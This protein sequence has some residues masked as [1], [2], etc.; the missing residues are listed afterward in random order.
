MNSSFTGGPALTNQGFDLLEKLLHMDPTQR[1]SAEDALKHDY[2][3]E[4]PLRKHE[5]MMPT[6][7]ATNAQSHDL[8]GGG[9]QQ[10]YLVLGNH[11]PPAS[12]D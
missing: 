3:S 1:I 6:F 5:D 4:K 7:P 2:F 10:A 11:K 8:K 12:P 9:E